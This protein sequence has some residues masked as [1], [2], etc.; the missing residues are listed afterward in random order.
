MILLCLVNAYT[1]VDEKALCKALASML[2]AF[3]PCWY[4]S[5][6]PTEK[7]KNDEMRG[8]GRGGGKERRWDVKK[9]AGDANPDSNLA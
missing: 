5:I 1:K 6:R 4:L 9:E 8:R 7:E 2:V 3:I